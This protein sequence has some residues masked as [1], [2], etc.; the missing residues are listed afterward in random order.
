MTKIT[1]I[2]I[3]PNI[4]DLK[5]AYTGDTG[6]DLRAYTPYEDIIIKP[7]E[8]KKVRTG[9][10][11]DIPMGIDAQ[12]R[13]RSGIAEKFAT[14]ILNSPG[15]IDPGYKGEI[16]VLLINF[17]KRPFV[18]KHNDKIAQICFTRRKNIELQN[19][20]PTEQEL[21]N[22]RIERSREHSEELNE[23]QP[24]TKIRGNKGFGSSGIN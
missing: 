11:M 9:I 10:L 22:M 23:E 8:Y 15:T 13:P 3:D 21:S 16:H 1:Y 7:L 19:K 2:K 18:I 6:F 20:N 14:T 12:I 4:P 5:T 24:N 17:G